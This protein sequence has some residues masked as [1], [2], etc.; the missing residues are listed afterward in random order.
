MR[1]LTGAGLAATV[2]QTLPRSELLVRLGVHVGRLLGPEGVAAGHAGKGLLQCP[3][4]VDDRELL[5][6]AALASC[7]AN[8]LLYFEILASSSVNI[9]IN[10]VPVGSIV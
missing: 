4:G 8:L 2:D 10:N 5:E 1:R 3:T 6:A 9:V 7:L